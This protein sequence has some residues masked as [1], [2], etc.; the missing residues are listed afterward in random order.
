MRLVCVTPLGAGHGAIRR[1]IG[2]PHVGRAG[3]DVDRE[4]FQQMHHMTEVHVAAQ[5]KHHV[6]RCVEAACPAQ[7]I[8]RAECL[9]QMRVAQDIAPERMTLEEQVLKVVEDEFRGA[10]FI[11]L[12]LVENDLHLLPYLLLRE[13]AV[14]HDVGEQ[15]C[16]TGKVLGHEGRVDDGF[17]LVGERVQVAP[18]ALHAVQ[19]V[20]HTSLLRALED[21]VFDKV[22]HALL[23]LFFVARTGI[24]GEPGVCHRRGRRRL[25]DA[26]SVGQRMLVESHFRSH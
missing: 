4:P 21:E 7:G 12:Y 25:D 6:G 13:G 16:R 24:D 18:D 9:Q 14:K 8:V 26:Q 17:F 10:V 23:A 3:N 2:S 11:A 22:R 1:Q 15:L 5:K 19:D 20:P